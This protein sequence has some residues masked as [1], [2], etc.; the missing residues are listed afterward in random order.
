M[1]SLHPEYWSGF[2]L[3]YLRLYEEDKEW[4]YAEIWKHGED[5]E[6]IIRRRNDYFEIMVGDEWRGY[7]FW[8]DFPFK[9][10]VDS[11]GE[12]INKDEIVDGILKKT[13]TIKSS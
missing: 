7:K 12:I 8:Y 11:E 5:F 3:D 2:L 9:I 13:I 10:E 6:I 1:D 4:Y